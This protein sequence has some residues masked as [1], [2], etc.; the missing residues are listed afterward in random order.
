MTRNIHETVSVRV[1]VV[2]SA[3]DGLGTANVTLDLDSMNDEAIGQAMAVAFRTAH[4]RALV[5][6][7]PKLSAS[8]AAQ[9]ERIR[10]G[11]DSTE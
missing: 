3:D 7:G 4:T 8:W 10:S 9:G 11:D 1:S 5:E 2:G 6:F